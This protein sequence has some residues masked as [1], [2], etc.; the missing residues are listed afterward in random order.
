MIHALNRAHPQHVVSTARGFAAN[1]Q[2]SLN[3]VDLDAAARSMGTMAPPT[4]QVFALAVLV[5][6]D[7]AAAFP[8]V[9]Q[10]FMH[11]LVEFALFLSPLVT[12][13]TPRDTLINQV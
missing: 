5:F 13:C 2:L 9:S 4:S 3:A 1:R 12:D 7:L 6:F 8:L 10:A 11:L